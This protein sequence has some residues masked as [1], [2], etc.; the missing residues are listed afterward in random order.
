MPGNR[1]LRAQVFAAVL[2][3]VAATP[4]TP[5]QDP[6]AVLGAMRAELTRSLE[7]F[8]TQSPP[9]YFMTYEISEVR[10]ATV[11]A[12]FGAVT[13]SVEELRRHLDV[14]VRAETTP[15]TTRTPS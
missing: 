10:S 13:E 2:V 1:S 15:S 5:L 6:G 7:S 8:R 12:S 4:T 9:P 11:S 3:T 14:E